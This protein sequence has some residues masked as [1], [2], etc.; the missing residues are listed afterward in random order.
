MFKHVE[1]RL[2]SYESVGNYRMLKTMDI[3]KQAFAFSLIG[4]WQ[5]SKGV[6]PVDF[7]LGI[8]LRQKWMELNPRFERNSR[9]YP[10][11]V[12]GELLSGYYSHVVAGINLQLHLSRPIQ[13]QIVEKISPGGYKGRNNK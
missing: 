6:L 7:T 2:E 11:R 9:Q 1:K 4:G 8:G 10:A 12:F 13:R 5:K 3:R